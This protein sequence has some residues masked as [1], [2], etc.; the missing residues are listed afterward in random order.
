MFSII[1]GLQCSV[2]FLLYSK[3]DIVG[4]PV[5]VQQNLTSSQEDAGL[6]PGPAQW[7]KDLV[8]P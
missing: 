1:A 3:V 5:V 4:I 2:N 8:M 6:I 7:V